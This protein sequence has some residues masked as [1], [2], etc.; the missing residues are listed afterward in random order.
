VG[1]QDH[2]QQ[3]YCG[4]NAIGLAFIERPPPCI[5]TARLSGMKL[6]NPLSISPRDPRKTKL[7]FA[8]RV[9]IL[10]KFKVTTATLWKI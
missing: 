7:M 4:Q 8:A 10:T 3:Q 9:Q 6:G 1:I 5:R 2:E